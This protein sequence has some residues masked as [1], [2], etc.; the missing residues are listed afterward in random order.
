[1]TYDIKRGVSLYSFQNDTFLGRMNLE[2]CIR[3]CA[4]MGATG[5]EIIGEQTF[6]GWPEVGVAP[7]K[8]AEWHA[9]MA[10]YGTTPV[11]HDFMLDYKRYKGQPMPF[12]EQVASVKKDIEFGA[13]LGMKFIRS[14]VSVDPEVLVAA[15]P[16][17]EEKGIKIL[18]E[19]HAPLHF[20]H[21]W[22]LRHA[23]AYEK[24]GTDALGFLPDMGVF[25][26]R[27]PRVWKERFIRN[28]VPR[29][30]ADFIEAGFNDRRLAEYVVNDV[31]LKWGPGPQMGMVETLR[32]NAAFSPKRMLDFM[33]RIHNIHAKFYEMTEDLV[34]FSIPYDEVFA[35]L[36]Q[37]GYK[38]HICSEYEGNRWVED[39]Q[40]VESVEQVRRQQ[41]MFCNLL[42]E[43][44]P[45]TLVA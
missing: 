31:M 10:K 8:I 7:E 17:A 2:D 25:L 6:W 39:A 22:I 35:V 44:M 37:G 38:G 19:V 40:E 41:L 24:A 23:E 32:H 45:Q 36:K 9:L 42:G 30:A 20:D 26:Y 33:P 21:P 14:L 18:L 15:A 34:E 29:E 43:T 5:I 13:L 12:A 4:E 1:M 11:C 3:T 27:Y 28:G 16:F